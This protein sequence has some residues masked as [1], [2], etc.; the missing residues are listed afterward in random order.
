MGRDEFFSVMMPHAQ[1][2]SDRTGIDPRLV[3]AQAAL[4]TGYG[5][6]APN[7]NFFGIKSHGR[8][9]GSN[10]QTKEFEGGRM[11]TKSQSFRGYSDPGQSFDD[12]ADFLLRNK[13]YQPVLNAGGLDAQIAAMGNSGYATDPNYASKLAQIAG[14]APVGRAQGIADD[15]MAAIGKQP[16][17]RGTQTAIGGSGADTMNTPQQGLLGQIARP[18]EK[19]GGLLGMMFGNMS[20]DRADQL[21]ANLGGLQG[22]NNQGMVDAARGR[23][24][25]RSGARENDLN[26]NRKQ[27]QVE[28]ERARAIDFFKSQGDT[29]GMFADAIAA[30]GNPGQIIESFVR[31]ASTA[32]DPAVQSSQM[33]PDQSGTIFNMR[34]GSL[35]VVTIG[36]ETLTGQAAV[37]F[38]RTAQENYTNNQRSIYGARQDGRNQADIES[39]GTAAATI[40]AATNSI[41][42]GKEAWSAYGQLNS[43]I[44]TMD[45]AIA[46]LDAG[47]KSGAFQKFLPNITESSARL[48]NAMDRMGLDVISATTFGALSEG[49]LRLAMETA[50]PRNLD[51]AE[52]RSWLTRRRDAQAKAADMLANAAQYLSTPGNNL[53]GWIDQNRGSSTPA[54]TGGG[55]PAAAAPVGD[56]DLLKMYGE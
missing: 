24:R 50:V 35:Q 40:E 47:G 22:I 3:L 43:S 54:P 28:Q 26:Y 27:Q 9:G 44:S 39:G 5:K 19:V 15:A 55:M 16:M 20:P 56:D 30:G 23:M 52:L 11:V 29:G 36:G 2:V 7:N 4:E 49:E 48:T 41:N 42:L 1:R 21:R 13:R 46:A 12:Y 6:S 45:E 17:Q 37:D 10:L 33:M 32:N 31:T 18:D 38:V 8:G 34:D 53:K 51:E 25:A 14:A